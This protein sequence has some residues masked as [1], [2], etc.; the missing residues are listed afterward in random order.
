MINDTPVY[1]ICDLS[2]FKEDDILISRFAPYLLR[3][4]NLSAA[5]G[6]SFYHLVLFT[7]GA[8]S[9]RIDFE[10]FEVKPWQIYFMAPGQVHSWSFEGFIDGYVVNFSDRFF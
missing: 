6:H 3:H 8:G 5:H 4:K 2:D 9:H 1:D 7:E 10:Q